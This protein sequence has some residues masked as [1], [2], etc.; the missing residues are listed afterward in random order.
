[1]SLIKETTFAC[2]DCESTGLDPEQDRIV[3]I[4]IVLFKDGNVLKQSDTLINPGIEIPQ[5]S[6]DIHHI[7]NKMCQGQPTI[8]EALPE[9]LELL[10]NHII[11]GHGINF[12]ISLID[13]EAKRHRIP[14]QISKNKFIDTLRMARLYG[15][16][17]IN[18]LDALRSHFNIEEEGAHRALNDVLVNVQVFSQLAKDF[19]TTAALMKRLEDP[20]ALRNMPLGKHKGRPFNEVPADYLRW[21]R[22]QNFDQDLLFSIN[23][24]LKKRKRGSFS[25]KSN[26][27]HNFEL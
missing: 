23:E 13:H 21:A 3:E 26:P 12:D 10:D 25:Q 27:F 6:I 1:M 18:S 11:V 4:A 17:P 15:G 22:H 20:I 7:T 8:K 19:K 5:E 16:S 24:E 2:I 9:I 14:C